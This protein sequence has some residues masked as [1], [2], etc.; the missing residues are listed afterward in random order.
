MCIRDSLCGEG[1]LIS[2]QLRE[3]L[4]CVKDPTAIADV[5]G[6]SFLNDPDER[7]FL[8]EMNDVNERL[9]FL[10]NHLSLLVKESG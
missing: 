1:K 10:V 2:D 7:Q 6:Q 3:H 4:R 8:L 5:V 9:E